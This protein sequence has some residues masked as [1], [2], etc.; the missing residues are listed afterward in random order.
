MTSLLALLPY[1]AGTT[2]SQRFRIEQW[3]PV[4]AGQGI[5]MTLVPF[6]NP[7]LMEILHRPGHRL[8]KAL[9]GTAALLRRCA[10]AVRSR[11]YDVVLIHRAASL[12]GPALIER[13]LASTGSRIVFD[14][15]DAI[16]LLHTTD[17]NR[18]LGRLKSPGKTAALCR[19]SRAVVVANDGLAEYARRHNPS[20]TVIPSSVD[21][22][23]FRPSPGARAP[24][25][26][27][28]GWTG[29]STSL[30]YLEMFAPVLRE[31]NARLPIELHVHSDR[32]PVLAGLPY[33]FRP[34][35]PETEPEEL[36]RFDIGIMP[37]PDDPWARGKSAM[38]A[39]L[40][41]A[42]GIPVVAAD[43]GTNRDVIA[44]GINGLLA[45]TPQD[46]LAALDRLV[47]D[48]GERLRLGA[49]GRRTV[50]Q[51]YSKDKCGTRMAEVVLGV[52]A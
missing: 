49:A 25:P 48:A 27:R 30:T 42:M 7:R 5:R 14:F 45:G 4:L 2:P 38:K 33:V 29:S 50:E 52:A 23:A 37:M 35:R 40:C 13:L 28:V 20:V 21:T 26:I 43:V 12:A 34:W 10:A 18:H 39:L 1:P 24:G 47:R 8:A 22:D 19:L 36:G 9:L 6:A 46:W 11:Q 31:A 16:W 44:S 32:E 15:D 51:R 3:E 41:M 17:A